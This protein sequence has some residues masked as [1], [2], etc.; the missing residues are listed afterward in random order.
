MRF[1]ATVHNIERLLRYLVEP[2]EPAKR[3]PAR[4]PLYVRSK[5]LRRKFEQLDCQQPIRHPKLRPCSDMLLHKTIPESHKTPV[6]RDNSIL[7]GIIGDFRCT[8]CHMRPRDYAATPLP[9]PPAEYTPPLPERCSAPIQH[10]ASTRDTPTVEAPECAARQRQ[11]AASGKH[12]PLPQQAEQKVRGSP[13]QTGPAPWQLRPFVGHLATMVRKEAGRGASIAL[14]IAAAA[15]CE[16]SQ[17]QAI[18]AAT[19]ASAGGAT[20]GG[21]GGVTTGGSSTTPNTLPR[22]CPTATCEYAGR[23]LGVGQIVPSIGDCNTC[24]C[25]VHVNPSDCTQDTT[26]PTCTQLDCTGSCSYAGQRYASGTTFSA[27]D[28]CNQ[29]SCSEGIVSCGDT[30]CSCDAWQFWR[31]YEKS[32]AGLCDVIDFDCPAG[33][34]SFA[35]ACGCGCEQSPDCPQIMGCVGD[36]YTELFCPTATLCPFGIPWGD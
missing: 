16:C 10:Q 28:G 3:A 8:C 15:A 20:M 7:S 5:V 24:T 11:R 35:N 13:Q 9:Q 2:L 21:A 25:N 19:N 23:I 29:C 30:P 14:W 33:T 34:S 32:D 18:P 26:Q 6:V 4:D 22:F 31:R 17:E 12:R 1:A 36:D 27:T